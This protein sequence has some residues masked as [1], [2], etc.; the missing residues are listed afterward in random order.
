[1]LRQRT[2]VA[3]ILAPVTLLATY[4]GGVAY[5]LLI[6]TVL[7]IAAWEYTQLLRSAKLEPA[8]FLIIGGVLL[9]VL[10]RTLTEFKSAHWSLTLLLIASIIYHLVRFEQNRDTAATDF[11]A[12]ISAI[13]YIGWLGAYFISLRHLEGGSWWVM[14]IFFIVWL[15][16]SG[17]Y[18]IGSYFGKHPL[19]PR[20]SP[21]KTWE[22]FWGG[23][24]VGIL[25]GALLPFAFKNTGIDITPLRG[26]VLGLVLAPIIPLGDL[27]ESMVKRQAAKKDSGTLL[28][29]HGG[30]FDRID[31]L[32]WAMP[33]SYYLIVYLLPKL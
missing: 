16:D 31:T 6:I 8:L 29:G 30:A 20:L 9:L 25:G 12:T 4:Y 13:L 27:A 23:V 24:V 7:L 21:R 15:T 18:F 11:G 2:I 17:A 22:G 14:F 26:A 19:A 3:L 10:G 32:L 28:P 1:M 5:N 33:I